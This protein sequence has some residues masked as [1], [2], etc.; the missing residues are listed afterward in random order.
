MALRPLHGTTTA[1]AAFPMPLPFAPPDPGDEEDDLSPGDGHLMPTGWAQADIFC[2]SERS[3]RD[4]LSRITEGSHEGSDISSFFS[5][6]SV[7]R[8]VSGVASS[9][10]NCDRKKHRVER[11]LPTPA[12][13]VSIE[14][15]PEPA[16]TA[17]LREAVRAFV[18][19]AVRG[20]RIEVLSPRGGRPQVMFFRLGRHVEAFELAHDGGNA[21][22]VVSLAEIAR[23]QSA[24]E[25]VEQQVD[26]VDLYQ[27]LDVGCVVVTLQDG[28]GLA[29]RLLG[30]AASKAASEEAENFARVLQMLS[31][32]F[33]KN[34]RMAH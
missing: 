12:R 22:H 27:G 9:S 4:N 24:Q 21:G 1:H 26:L 14:S 13:A 32:E 16:H 7:F 15:K 11:K 18:E 31:C 23:A 8:S 20:R 10:L 28:R 19:T 17:E 5:A 34:G 30:V 2:G 29:F 33:R 25:A 3:S 6:V